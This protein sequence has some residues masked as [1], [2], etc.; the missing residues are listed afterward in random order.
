MMINHEN[1]YPE[2]R[3]ND[4]R[5]CA[6]PRRALRPSGRRNAARL[7]L[8][9][10]LCL[11]GACSRSAR[12]D[13]PLPTGDHHDDVPAPT[14]RIDVPEAVR[15]NLGISFARVEY[16]AVSRTLRVPGRF[17]LEP[18]A[19]REYRTMLSGRVELHVTQYQ[20][21]ETGTL[22]FTLDSPNWRELQQRLNETELQIRQAKA[23]FEN[24]DPLLAA[25]ERHHT[26]LEHGVALWQR[27][28]AEIEPLEGSGAVAAQEI[29]QVRAAL[30]SA[31]AALAET[32]EKEAELLSRKGE[33]SAEWD[34]ARERFD[35]LLANAGSLLGID[36][37]LLVG[38]APPGRGLHVHPG[39]VT[40]HQHPLWRE[41]QFVEVRAA[42]PGIVETLQLTN[43]AWAAETSLVLTTVQP[44]RLRFR[45]RGLQSDLGRLRDGLPARIVPPKGG[46]IA[47]QDTMTGSITLGL[48]ADA[49][50]RTVEILMTPAQLAAWARPGV[51]GHL[52]IVTEGLDQPELAI[53]LSATIRDGLTTVIFRRDP[54]N[55]DKVIRLEADLGI[56]DGRWVAIH[57][58]VKE[59]DEVV[60]DGVY[61]LMLASS[62][63]AQT[64]GH[65]HADGT[66]HADPD[67]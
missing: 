59:G 13:A 19:R 38:P 65:F 9:C 10:C 45:A 41:L 5:L 22:L 64:G 36:R 21:V 40:P 14:N 44:D 46:S 32:L 60:L 29:A 7:S 58:G 43:G 39:E 11:I 50:E 34:A 48:G 2:R 25:H 1:R 42:S 47:L 24:I 63:V 53:P 8:L 57:S 20:P 26:E 31:R 23:R 4:S 16:R 55:P 33:I 3:R 27:R 67:H 35:L 51:A 18:H 6:A 28:A 15:R 52:E 17:E 66:F 62:N 61:Q 37:S 56:H 49:D 30:F 54:K 12:E